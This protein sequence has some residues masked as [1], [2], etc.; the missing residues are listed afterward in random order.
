MLKFKNWSEMF[1]PGYESGKLVSLNKNEKC[2]L[3]IF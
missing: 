2:V 1:I 3:F